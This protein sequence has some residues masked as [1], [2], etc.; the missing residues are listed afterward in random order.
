MTTLKIGTRSSPL[1]MWQANH[2]AAALRRFHPRVTVELV[3]VVTEGDRRLDGPLSASGGKGLFLK[4]LEV[5]LLDGSIDIAVHSM[6]DVTVTL[7]EGLHIAVVLERADPRDALIS[8]RG[9]ALN[10]LPPDSVLGTSSLRRRCQLLSHR[11]DLQVV[12]MRGNVQ[13]RL[14]K[15][16]RGDCH[17]TVLAVAGLERLGMLDLATAIMPPEFSLPAVGQGIVGCE[18]RCDDTATNALLAPLHHERSHQCLVAERAVNRKLD[19]G[20]HHPIAAFAQHQAG[21]INLR[22]MVGSVDGSRIIFESEDAPV[23]D[24]NALG[25]RVAERLLA[26]GASDLLSNARLD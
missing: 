2:V 20:C 16:N 24:A 11:P 13:T 12:D 26:R 25:E 1:A 21:G 6:K 9:N 15:L 7:P 10:D 5:A 8:T 18:T 19:G 22:A 14:K 3:P 17:A 4:E 23:D